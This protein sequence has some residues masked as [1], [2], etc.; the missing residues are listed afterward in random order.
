VPNS[1][2][3]AARSCLKHY[4]SNLELEKAKTNYDFVFELP[5]TLAPFPVGFVA[6]FPTYHPNN[7]TKYKLYPF[8]AK[9]QFLSHCYRVVFFNKNDVWNFIED[10]ERD[11][12][13]YDVIMTKINTHLKKFNK[14]K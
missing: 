12:S 10:F 11:Y 4:P 7:K 8:G 1:V 2:R 14:S 5:D 13:E 9:N 3:E 6:A